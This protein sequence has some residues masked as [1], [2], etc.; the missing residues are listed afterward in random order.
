MLRVGAVCRK[1]V[2]AM[3]TIKMNPDNAIVSGINQDGSQF[4]KIYSR[5]RFGNGFK[6]IAQEKYE[7]LLFNNSRCANGGLSTKSR[8]FNRMT[9]K[10]LAERYVAEHLSHTKG[11]SAITFIRLIID[12]WGDWRLYQINTNMVRQWLWTFLDGTARQSRFPDKPYHPRAARGVKT[13]FVRIFNWGIEAEIIDTNPLLKLLDNSL[14]K[15]FN[16]KIKSRHNPI[17]EEV[18]ESIMNGSPLW[19]QRVARHAWGTGMRRAEITKLKWNM[20][21]DNLIYFDAEHTKEADEKVIPMEPQVI[22]QINAIR[23]EQQFEGTYKEDGYIYLNVTNNGPVTIDAITSSWKHYRKKAN[24][25]GYN[26]H[27]IRSTWE[28]RKEQAGH[29]L[30]AIAAALG[31]HST[32]TTIRHYRNVSKEELQ[33]LA[34][35]QPK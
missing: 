24:C 11:L 15:E 17:P 31:H 27:D 28:N 7:E 34:E 18:F 2:Q 23:L 32:E 14:R 5:K 25:P 30:R 16:R 8:N 1:G 13:F 20:I 12:K 19:F 29:S 33:R 6:K 10:E 4:R 22:D 9:V 26:F 21:H 35:T 3:A